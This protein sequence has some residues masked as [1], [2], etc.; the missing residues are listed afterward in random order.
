M[1]M[2]NNCHAVKEN[3][4]SKTLYVVNVKQYISIE[5]KLLLKNNTQEII[6]SLLR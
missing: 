3:T 5:I 1:V 4:A 6:I 2:N